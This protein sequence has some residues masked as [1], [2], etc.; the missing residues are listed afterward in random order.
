MQKPF[1]ALDAPGAAPRRSAQCQ[2]AGSGLPADNAAGLAGQQCA[3][4]LECRRRAPPRPSRE[5]SAAGPAP[6]LGA[7][8]STLRSRVILGFPRQSEQIA[9]ASR[10]AGGG[11]LPRARAC[12]CGLGLEPDA[13]ARSLLPR[14]S[15]GCEPVI[16]GCCNIFLCFLS[17]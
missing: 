8:L 7:A 1:T 15:A 2:T 3:A 5:R 16:P 13:A 12:G 17:P 9:P 6:R 14:A 11:A 4:M 10:A